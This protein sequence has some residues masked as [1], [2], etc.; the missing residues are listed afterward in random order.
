[1]ETITIKI[2]RTKTSCLFFLSVENE[3]SFVNKAV[4]FS[5]NVLDEV[6]DFQDWVEI[7]RGREMSRIQD[8]LM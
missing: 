6:R 5:F 2:E 7:R 3:I 4:P 8:N 1:M